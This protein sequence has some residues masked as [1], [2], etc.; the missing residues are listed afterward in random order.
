M[1]H[2]ILYLRSMHAAAILHISKAFGDW[3]TF[4][5]K[6][7]KLVLDESFVAIVIG[8][9]EVVRIMNHRGTL[10][11]TKRHPDLLVKYFRNYLAKSFSKKTRREIMKFH[12]QFL[13]HICASFH[14]QIL[15]NGPVLWSDIKDDNSYTISL[16]FNS[17]WHN[18]GDI[19]L[20][21]NQNDISLYEI[22]FTIVPGY[23]INSAADAV[24]LVGRVQGSKYHADAIRSATRACHE[25]APPHLLLAATQGIARALAIDAIGGVSN[26]EHVSKAEEGEAAGFFFNYDAFWETFAVKESAASIYEIPVP[27]AQKPLKLINVAHRRRTR[28]KRQFKNHIAEVVGAAFAETFLKMQSR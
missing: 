16:S 20:T 7:P 2:Y 4:A 24:L 10:L 26:K 19:S 27:F 23:S 17:K 14:E 12:Y 3:T 9:L 18:E 25:V 21:L 8:H 13:E 5:S 28:R 15:D 1:G 22:S 11:L 6:F